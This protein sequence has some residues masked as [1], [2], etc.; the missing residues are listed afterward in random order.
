MTIHAQN[1][2]AKANAFD[3]Q[4]HINLGID[5]GT[6]YT[7][8]CYRDLNAEESMVA[9]IGRDGSVLSSAIVIEPSGRLHLS[10]EHRET[11]L[12]YRIEYLKMRLSG[13]N[14]LDPR[15]PLIHGFDL[16]STLGLRALSAWFLASV[17][18]K[19]Q[20][21]IVSNDT[22]RLRNLTPV[23]SANIGIPVDHFDSKLMPIFTEVFRVSWIW[24]NDKS[25]QVENVNRLRDAYCETRDEFSVEGSEGSEPI[26]CHAVPEIA[27]AIYPF[28]M[29]RDSTPGVYAHFDVGGGTLDGVSFNFRGSGEKI[30]C[31]AA[32]VKQLG[33]AIASER[34]GLCYDSARNPYKFDDEAMRLDHANCKNSIDLKRDINKLVGYVVMNARKKIVGHFDKQAIHQRPGVRDNLLHPDDQLQIFLGGGG[35][36][37]RWYRTAIKATHEQFNQHSA[38]VPPFDLRPLSPPS[39]LRGVP[40]DEAPFRHA[41]S[42]GLSIPE[43][44]LVSVRE[45][46]VFHY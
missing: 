43:G 30:S 42:Y 28:A 12:D 5:F 10:D 3:A 7:K 26:D 13:G 8:V 44:E 4:I 17:V 33:I 46:A 15:P 38:G 1:V 18:R 9:C 34:L 22:E 16:G 31:L 14:R 25:F 20:T 29:S 19:S 27:A 41:I 6:S 37:S 21:W 39:D 35:S 11:E 36:L 2:H 23:W 40:E 32:E 45:P 24:A